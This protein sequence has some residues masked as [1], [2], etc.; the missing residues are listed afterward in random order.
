MMHLWLDRAASEAVHHRTSN[1][2]ILL[3]Q[4]AEKKNAKDARN[5]HSC[6]QCQEYTATEIESW[7]LIT[8]T[9]L[10]PHVEGGDQSSDLA[11]PRPIEVSSFACQNDRASHAIILRL[12]SLVCREFYAMLEAT[13]TLFFNQRCL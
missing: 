4:L 3:D 7:D 1:T 13:F 8:S 9:M 2:K 12:W 11:T 10:V 5:L 6:M